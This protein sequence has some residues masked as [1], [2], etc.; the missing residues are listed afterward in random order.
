M[1]FA[2]TFKYLLGDEPRPLRI[3]Q[4]YPYQPFS[5]EDMIHIIFQTDGRDMIGRDAEIC[6]VIAYDDVGESRL[7]ELKRALPLV[8][9]D[10]K[11]AL[12]LE[13]ECL[14]ATMRVGYG[15]DDNLQLVIKDYWA[16]L[17]EHRLTA[18]SSDAVKH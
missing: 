8:N 6:D 13:G 17:R 15:H 14:F 12:D 7:K 1:S 4:V 3:V 10:K 16:P 5:G 18:R 2:K 11:E 9:Q